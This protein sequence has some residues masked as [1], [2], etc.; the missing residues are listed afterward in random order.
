MP[1]GQYQITLHFAELLGGKVKVPPYNLNDNE[2]TENIVRRVF[3]VRIN[4]R[5][6][7]KEFNIAKEYGLA[8]AVAKTA[9]VAVNNNEGLKID[10]EA[11]EGEPVLNALQ[12]KKISPQLSK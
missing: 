2:R 9:V 6:L 8:K 11:L 7:L 4:G 3:N 12:L 10:F 5:M 1:P